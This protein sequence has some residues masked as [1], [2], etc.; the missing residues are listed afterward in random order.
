MTTGVD[1]KDL[2]HIISAGE[3]RFNSDIHPR[4]SRT[5]TGF[6]SWALSPPFLVDLRATGSMWGY[7]LGY[8]NRVRLVAH[9]LKPFYDSVRSFLSQLTVPPSPEKSRKPH[10]QRA[11]SLIFHTGAS[12]CSIESSAPRLEKS[13]RIVSCDVK[14]FPLDSRHHWRK[15]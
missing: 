7:I 9:Y 14:G 15:E 1:C 4:K 8:K 12:A 2:R 11:F 5:M 3:C 10:V 13:G 6:A